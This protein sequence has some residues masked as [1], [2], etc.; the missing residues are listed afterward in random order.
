[1]KQCY[2]VN[3]KRYDPGAAFFRIKSQWKSPLVKQNILK[4]VR[5]ALV[6][7]FFRKESGGKKL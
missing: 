7:A 5:K 1:M 6:A 2:Q 4:S 3:E